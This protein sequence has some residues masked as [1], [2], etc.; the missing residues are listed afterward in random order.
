VT[1]AAV[2]SAG[3]GAGAGAGAAVIRV[4]RGQP[5]AEEV[6]AVTVVLLAWAA[7]P[8]DRAQAAERRRSVGWRRP[9]R[10]RLV[11]ETPGW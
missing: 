4:E 11:G 8:A 5:N 6:A 1:R 10:A 9:E 3:A 7:A 2:T